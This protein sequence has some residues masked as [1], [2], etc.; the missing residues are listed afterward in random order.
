[1]RQFTDEEII[2]AVDEADTR[3]AYVMAHSHTDEAARRCAELGVR[4]IEHGTMIERD[5]TAELIAAKRAFVVPTLSVV[6]VQLRHSSELRHL[7]SQPE[8]LEFIKSVYSLMLESIE[9]CKRA[10]VRLGLGTDLLGMQFH[11][12][13]GGEL[14]LRGAV[15]RPIDVLRSATSVNAE[16]LKQSGKLGCIRAGAYADLLV[17]ADDP[18]E[19]LALFR[20]PARNIPLVMRGGEF[21]RNS[22][23]S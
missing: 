7:V 18:F 10:G 4:T 12:F 3:R 20:E 1:M 17:L 16:I 8:K 14:E 13:Q 23:A 19:N 11:P 21:I 15:E 2:A 6:D 9:R 22:L 5:A